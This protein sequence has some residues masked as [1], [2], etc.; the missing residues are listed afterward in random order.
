MVKASALDGPVAVGVV[1]QTCFGF[2]V[3][4]LVEGRSIAAKALLNALAL[5]H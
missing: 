4:A 2:L 3:A 1:L 5:H